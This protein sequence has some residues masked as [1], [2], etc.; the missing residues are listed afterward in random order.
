MITGKTKLLA[1]IGYPIAHSLSPVMHNAAIA[2]LQLDYVYIPLAIAPEN[3]AIAVD[4]LMAIELQGFNV[5]IPHKEAIFQ[6]LSEKG[7][8]DRI[9]H[10]VG[11]VNT[12]SRRDRT[13][14]G[15]NTDIAGFLAP[16]QQCDRDWSQ[17]E[18][19]IL[20]YGGAARAVVA[21]CAKLGCDRV[22]V[23]GRDP[24]K[25]EEFGKS[26]V[27]SP[28]SVN[29]SLHQ[30]QELPELMAKTSLLVNATPVGM[31]NRSHQSPVDA[32]VMAKLPSG[33]IAYDLIYNPNPT[34]FLQ[35]ARSQGKMAIDG[36]E[37]LICQGA[38][39]LEI[40]LQ[41][42]APLEIMRQALRQHLG[43]EI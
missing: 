23:V 13:W 7:E 18:A 22:N 2:N 26:W 17:T 28:L 41:Q 40:W 27:N 21:A 33:A 37:M 35:Q 31:G 15:T 32:E 4:G 42:P 6:L 1:V 10:A 39:A 12:V 8:V 20:G 11:A 24:K 36:L 38:A 14:C 9:A 16:L 25:L 3:L 30:W 43:F 29:L 19:T 34:L 5:T